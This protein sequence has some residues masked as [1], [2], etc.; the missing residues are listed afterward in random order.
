MSIL[1]FFFNLFISILATTALATDLPPFIK[2]SD[3]E[4]KIKLT[5][6]QYDV[7]QKSQTE[8]PFKNEYWNS[9]ASGIFVDIVSGDPLF[10]SLDKYDSGTGWP[11]FTKPIENSSVFTIDDTSFLSTRTEVRSKIANSH[12]GHV[13][14]DGPAPLGLRYCMNSAS[15]R[16]VPLNEMKKQGYG[17]LLALFSSTELAQPA[18]QNTTEEALFA[19]GCF[20]CVESAFEEIEGV[21]SAVSGYTGGSK[22]N[23]TYEEVSAGNTGH[24]EA[25]KITFNPQK[26]SYAQL[27]EVFWHNVDPEAV[28]AQFCDHGNQYRSAI[29]YLNKKQQKIAIDTKDTILKSAKLKSKVATEIT[30]AGKFYPAETYHQDY[31]KKNPVRYQ[32]Y[33]AQCGRDRRLNEIWP[34]KK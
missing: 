23:P 18:S 30:F 4:L 21:L 9:K 13:F 15:L 6:L 2:P 25:V 29:F 12:L 11:S 20:W 28:N 3:A 17:R 32:F 22:L 33:R 27:L 10:S 16:F 34:L 8:S 26:I 31:Y 7:T 5:P 1:A 14:K 19:G 24:A